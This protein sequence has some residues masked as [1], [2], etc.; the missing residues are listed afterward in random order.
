M[1][2][3]RPKILLRY[4]RINEPI[5]VPIS[6][7]LVDAL[8][9]T[10]SQDV[11][12]G[13][14]VLPVENTL[15]FG[16]GGGVDRYKFLIGEPG[17]QRSEILPGEIT[18][19]QTITLSESTVYPHS[20]GTVIYQLFFDQVEYYHAPTELGVK[21]LLHTSDLL[22]K[23]TTTDYNDH[24]NDSGYYFARYKNTVEGGVAEGGINDPGVDYQVD[25]VLFLDGG[26]GSASIRVTSVDVGGE[27]TGFTLETPGEYY[28]VDSYDLLGGSGSGATFSVQEVESFSP[29]SD[30]A[31]WGG[32][33][34]QSARSIIDNALGEINKDDKENTS[35][36]LTDEFAFQQL[37]NYQGEVLKEQKRWSFMEVFNALIGTTHT[38]IWRVALPTEVA[39]QFT[40]KSI[41]HLRIGKL[42]DL[43]FVDK[44]KWDE[45]VWNVAHN[46]LAEEIEINDTEIVLENSGDFDNGGTVQIGENQYRYTDNDRENNVLTLAEPSETENE[47]GADVFQGASFGT[48]RF[49]TVFNGYAYHWPITASTLDGRNYYMDYYKKQTRIT[50]DS[51]LLV[52]DDPQGASYFLQW[53]FLKKLNNGEETEASAQMRDNY[54]ARREKLKQKDSIGRTFRLRPTINR[55]SSRGYGVRPNDP[56]AV[57]DGNFEN[58]G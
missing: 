40:N 39:D 13:E 37:D 29:F 35:E 36:T 16:G 19:Q 53:K 31:P 17:N 18:D 47:E 30:A 50:K 25:D 20:F 46:N 52:V 7:Q 22:A 32:Y 15:G 44:T 2:E 24:D 4:G 34:L 45:I 49:W 28:N 55:I 27:I 56:P 58:L 12:A 5:R 48:P 33:T 21:S 3:I 57:R 1:A 11:P 26:N 8:K 10:L 9:T 51:D 43:K 54:I 14:T 6:D 42:P 23:A 41:W 38:G